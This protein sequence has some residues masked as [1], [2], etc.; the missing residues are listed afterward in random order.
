[1]QRL[2]TTRLAQMTGDSDPDG[3][4]HYF[5]TGEAGVPGVD[6]GSSARYGDRTFVYFGD[7]PSHGD[8][9][10][11]GVIDDVRV[12]DG[13]SLAA[14]GQGPHQSDVF[15]I[16]ADGA[17]YVAWVV[18]QG[19]WRHPVQISRSG[20]APVGAHLATAPQGPDQLDV[21]F[22]GNDGGLYVAWVVGG[23]VWGGPQRIGSTGIAEPGGVLAA[24]HQ[25]PDQLDVVFI[26]SQ[27]RLQVAWV[28]GGGIW[29]GPQVIGGPAAYPPPGSGIAAHAQGGNQLDACFVG[30]DGAFY[31]AWV[32]GVGI[33]QGPQAVSRPGIAPAG[34]RLAA[35]AQTP[36]QVTVSFLDVNGVLSNMWVVGGG[37]WQGPAP[38]VPA[39]VP[40]RPGGALAVALQGDA[41]WDAFVAT[42]DGAIDVYWVDGGN[43]WQGPF[44]VA[45]AGSVS[46]RPDPAALIQAGGITVVAFPGGG[47]YL[48]I[49]W[50]DGGARWA[51]PVTINPL[52]LGLRFVMDGG[53]YYPFTVR[54]TSDDPNRIWQ[55]LTNQTPTGAFAWRNRMY[56]FVVADVEKDAAGQPRWISYLTSSPAPD[57]PSPYVTQRTL[58]AEFGQVAPVLVPSAAVPGL[59][60]Q[61]TAHANGVVLF[62]QGGPLPAGTPPRLDCLPDAR[63]GDASGI[64]VAYLPLRDDSDDLREPL[65]YY[66]DGGWHPDVTAATLIPTCYFWSS[67]SA[68]YVPEAGV[69]IVVYQLAGGLLFPASQGRPIVARAAA[70]PWG[71]A[72]APDV[73]LFDP[74]TDNAWGHYMNHTPYAF[75]YGAYLL[76]KYL[77]YDVGSRTLTL[78]YLMSTGDPYQVQLM[79]TTLR[80]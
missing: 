43:P 46:G 69:W 35:F 21:F 33:W 72:D 53:R 51:G 61:A 7:E 78:H 27:R 22:I 41:Q 31:V 8:T 75:P 5:P 62:G 10:P 19:T 58:P 30:Q 18:D 36:Q 26:D 34:A 63:P 37:T 42:A 64:H 16:G 17:L 59:P 67:V 3:L 48:R 14:G 80:L 50:V 56:V 52:M 68:A 11:I 74:T 6:L 66:S 79:R 39:A 15:F 55:P 70:T 73:V 77:A 57:Q 49:C 23:G 38:A 12:P 4:V 24:A 54:G 45:P 20:L 9:D 44:R 1:M 28:V 76:H 71:I 40:G 32:V 29:Q 13:A 60:P 25:T 2:N 47:G 65:L